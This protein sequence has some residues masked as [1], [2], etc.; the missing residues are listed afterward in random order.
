MAYPSQGV[1]TPAHEADLDA[2]TRNMYVALRTGEYFVP[3]PAYGSTVSR[4]V[5]DDRL[6]AFPFPVPR[7]LTID[8]L[9]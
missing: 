3:L 8:R 7:D 9:A 6:T 5:W 4:A 2:H 1:V